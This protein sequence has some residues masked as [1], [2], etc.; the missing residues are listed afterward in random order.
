MQRY[1][2]IFIMLP[3]AACVV[4]LG[5]CSNFQQRSFNIFADEA[6][7]ANAKSIDANATMLRLAEKAYEKG[8]Y[9]MAAQL[10]FR[11]AQHAPDTPEVMVKLGFALLKAGSA[12]D[13]ERVFRALLEKEPRNAPALRG[14]GHGLVLQKRPIEALSVYRQAIAASAK[15]EAHNYAGLGAALDLVGKHEEARA[16]YAAG[17]RL[18][19]NDLGLRNNLAISYAL[20][21]DTAKAKA[22]L[23]G[24]SQYPASR[25]EISEPPLRSEAI[26]TSSARRMLVRKRRA[27]AAAP[28]PAA[29]AVPLRAANPAWE[30]EM[31]EVPAPVHVAR[32][33][34][35]ANADLPMADAGNS[36]VFIRTGRASAARIEAQRRPAMS[37]RSD[38]ATPEEAAAEVLALL[39]Q[40]ARG[41]RFVWEQAQR[42]GS[43]QRA[44]RK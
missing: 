36:E 21:G 9:D 33:S 3:T 1:S 22:I 19:P 35:K 2:R 24:L 6:P 38:A 44:D 34:R 7:K 5:A 25:P 28:P 11:V 32:I 29:G 17:L 18:A 30:R 40:A 23:A 16:A 41:P 14:L 13:A 43:D 10:Y 26:K 8:E 12:A 15:P 37:F 42:P 4:V 27:V 39:E 20:S 31:V